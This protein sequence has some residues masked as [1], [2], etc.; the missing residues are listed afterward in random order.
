MGGISMAENNEDVGALN[1]LIETCKDAE[2]GFRTAAESVGKDGDAE[3]RTL[4]N[5]YAQQ[6]ARFAAELQNEV[7]RRGGD[8][9]KSG[10][11]SAGFQR[12]WMN[13][14]A[15]VSANSEASIIEEC[16]SGE[17]AAMRNYETAL[18]KNLPS[19]LFAI[20]EVQYAEIKQ[21]RDRLRGLGRAF[22]AG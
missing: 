14:K 13:L 21:A 3:L 16:K 19:D 9:A 15:A 8:P 22:K 12:S 2:Q 4:L 1:D 20:V 17:E 11:V 7:L 6:R 10:H 18:K 5:A